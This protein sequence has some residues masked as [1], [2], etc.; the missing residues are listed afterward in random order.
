[1][2][3]ALEN[4]LRT[5][6]RAVAKAIGPKG[7]VLRR[8]LKNYDEVTMADAKQST[9]YPVDINPVK[10]YSSNEIDGQRIIQG[11]VK[12]SL[13]AKDLPIL[14]DGSELV[15]NPETDYMVLAS[16]EYRVVAV[17]K[18]TGGVQPAMYVM[19]CRK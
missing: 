17:G 18:I 5:A 11:D 1:M 16:V 3:T 13:P 10:D 7:C 15:P 2:A 6:T 14:P 12:V 9:D 4:A 8:K 19:Q